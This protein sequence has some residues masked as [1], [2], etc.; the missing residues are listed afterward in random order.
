MCSLFID[1][2][3]FYIVHI[4]VQNNGL[5]LDE[6]IKVQRQVCKCVWSVF[7][8]YIYRFLSIMDQVLCSWHF[9][10][11]T[12]TPP[13]RF[14]TNLKVHKHQMKCFKCLCY[15]CFCYNFTHFNVV[16]A[17]RFEKRGQILP[18]LNFEIVISSEDI[19]NQL[20]FIASFTFVASKNQ[21]LCSFI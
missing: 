7:E 18:D 9:C 21:L 14:L 2:T 15:W 6:R 4:H 12:S 1:C 20:C 10:F 5:L 19:A 13:Y 11:N 17:S 8:R 3:L 16:Y